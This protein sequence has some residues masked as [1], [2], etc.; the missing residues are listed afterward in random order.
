MLRYDLTFSDRNDRD[1]REYAESTGNDRHDR[2]ARDLTVG[3]KWLPDEHWGVWAEQHFIDGSATAP[4]LE[5]QNR[6]IESDG[7]LFLLMVGYHF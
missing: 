2:F 1:G 5:N 7:A 4:S 6:T 3:L